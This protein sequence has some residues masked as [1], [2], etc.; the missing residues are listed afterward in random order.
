MDAQCAAAV[1]LARQVADGMAGAEHVGEHLGVTADGERVVTHNFAC[2]ESGYRGWRWAIT[3]ARAS[4]SRTI[5]VDEAVLLPGDGALL[6]PE[7]VPWSDRLRP[8]DLGPGDL[9]PTDEADE[10]LEPGYTG[11]DEEPAEFAQSAPIAYELGLGRARVLSAVGRAQAAQRWYEGAAGP[12]APMA[13]AA[14]A[15]CATCGFLVSVRGALRA[16]FGVCANQNSPSDGRVVAL[17]HGCGAHSEAAVMPA[18][19]EVVPPIVDDLGY[20]EF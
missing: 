3:L 5:T 13:Q 20:D 16:V 15:T 18:T 19:P 9:L 4:R 8:G 17:D 7:W 14:P 6:A 11:A 2:Q 12:R 1:D 10:R